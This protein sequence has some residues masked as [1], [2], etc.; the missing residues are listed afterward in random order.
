MSES[1]GVYLVKPVMLGIR[2]RLPLLPRTRS[3]L[4]SSR[5]LERIVW[6]TLPWMTFPLHLAA[7]RPPLKSPHPMVT[8]RSKSMNAA[9][10]TSSPVNALTISIGSA[11]QGLRFGLR[12]TTILWAQKRGT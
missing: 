1:C 10:V 3:E 11:P 9:G 8:A 4:S 6:E 12:S 7:V 2:R 5:K